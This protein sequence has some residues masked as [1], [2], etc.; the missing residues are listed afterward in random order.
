MMQ[1][2]RRLASY[3]SRACPAANVLCT[4]TYATRPLLSSLCWAARASSTADL[5]TRSDIARSRLHVVVGCITDVTG[6]DAIVNAANEHLVGTKLPYINLDGSG[7]CVFDC[8]DRAVHLRAGPELHAAC[9]A[10]DIVEGTESERWG[11]IR[12]PKGEARVTPSFAL[13]GCRFIVHVVGPQWPSDADELRDAYAATVA[14]ALSVDDADAGLRSQRQ[15]IRSIAI[16]AISSGIQQWP[17]DMS[18]AAA[19]ET[20][21]AHFL[22]LEIAPSSSRALES[23]TFAARDAASAVEVRECIARWADGTL[24]EDGLM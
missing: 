4:A 7:G 14:A 18:W 8:I 15:A 1:L 19:V 2:Q 6:V 5:A 13:Q 10:L 23:V 22:G 9:M 21:G 16:P 24:T 11:G 12:C 3:G 17:R 20:L